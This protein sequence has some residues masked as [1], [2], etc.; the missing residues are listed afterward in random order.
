MFKCEK[1]AGY[2]EHG[3][4]VTTYTDF[5]FDFNSRESYLEFRS[6]WRKEYASVSKKIREAKKDLKNEARS[7]AAERRDQGQPSVYYSLWKE[8]GALNTYRE[9]AR[10]L[11]AVRTASKKE[12]ARQMEKQREAA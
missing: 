7:Q 5:V 2:N 3:Q 11:M 8:Q 12:A 9:E 10:K 6:W 1:K 4:W